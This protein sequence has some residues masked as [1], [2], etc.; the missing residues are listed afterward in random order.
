M[1]FDQNQISQRI[2]WIMQKHKINQNQLALKLQ[3]TQPAVSKYLQGRVPPPIVLL[4]LAKLANTTIEWLLTG[5]EDHLIG[6]VTE[7]AGEYYTPSTIQFKFQSLPFDVQ[8]KLDD[9]ITTFAQYLSN[10]QT[11]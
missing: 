10:K 1:N 7:K 4:R 3:V 8:L 9:L 5:K 2:S 11:Y 6:K